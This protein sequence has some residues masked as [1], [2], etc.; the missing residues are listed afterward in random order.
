MLGEE[1]NA[2]KPFGSVLLV[3]VFCLT[4][5]IVFLEKGGSKKIQKREQLA[6]KFFSDENTISLE[7][8]SFALLVTQSWP[9]S[10]N[11][12]RTGWESS[13]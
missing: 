1:I 13:F 12:N 2:L 11:M 6:N 3:V 8:Q 4:C 5:S 10:E 9:L 7:A